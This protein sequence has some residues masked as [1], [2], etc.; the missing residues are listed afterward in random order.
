MTS[1]EQKALSKYGTPFVDK[2]KR[3][4]AELG[5]NYV[6][7]LAIM[8]S[9][10]GM[11]HTA[12]NPYAGATGLI[13]FMPATARGL[14]TS[15]EALAQMSALYQLD[16]VKKYYLSYTN[17]IKSP[18]DLYLITFYPYALGKPDTYIFGSEQGNEFA[19]LVK[20]QNAIFDL[21]GDGLITLGEF[22]KHKAE[23]TFKEIS[24]NE[25]DTT[26]STPFYKATWFWI[27]ILVIFAIG[28]WLYRDF[29]VKAYKTILAT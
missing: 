3:I 5:F 19:R 17:K 18:T 29:V 16:Y 2:V 13:Q 25:Q 12:V 8:V 24:Q 20:T 4:S 22:R 7:L 6:W 27:A 23:N 14:G 10:S 26:K 15:T 28:L 11:R 1:Y 9:E 21:N